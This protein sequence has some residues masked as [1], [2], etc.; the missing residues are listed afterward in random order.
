MILLITLPD[1]K[2]LI[3]RIKQ[4]K[5]GSLCFTE[6]ILTKNKRN[7]PY[8]LSGGFTPVKIG[9]HPFHIRLDKRTKTTGAVLCDQARTLD[10]NARNYEFIELI[11][12][13]IL[14]EVIIE[15]IYTIKALRDDSLHP[16][17]STQKQG[18]V[19]NK[20]TKPVYLYLSLRRCLKIRANIVL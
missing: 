10:I 13:D 6:Q 17:A 9:N 12:D 18:I 14:F 11:P 5:N 7:I 8:F 16:E 4:H 19:Y 3:K 2:I 1:E 15:T 20:N